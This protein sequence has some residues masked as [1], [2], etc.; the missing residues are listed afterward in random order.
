MFCVS[1]SDGST[2][3]IILKK[4]NV[5]CCCDEKL[6]G[7]LLTPSWGSKGG[8]SGVAP[9]AGGNQYA[10]GFGELAYTVDKT[11]A[12]AIYTLITIDFFFNLR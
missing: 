9:I 5:L 10:C 1:V 12:V 6:G 11:N 7:T 8:A 4:K 3:Y 2:L